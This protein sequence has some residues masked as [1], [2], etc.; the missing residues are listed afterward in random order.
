MLHRAYNTHMRAAP[1]QIRLE[2]GFDLCL[3]RIRFRLQ[4]SLGAH[5]H[6]GNAIAALSCLPGDERRLHRAGP[7]DRTEALDRYDLPS[8]QYHERRDAGK[9]SLVIH[10]DGAG[11]T[12]TEAAAELGSIQPQRVSQN[13]E[14]RGCRIFIQFVRAAIDLQRDHPVRLPTSNFAD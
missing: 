2:R 3:A 5:H 1:A 7:F 14:Q 13:I 11:T 4:Q 10:H 12:L 6:A 8:F 9:H